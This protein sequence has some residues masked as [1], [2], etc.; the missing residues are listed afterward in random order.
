MITDGIIT[1][2]SIYSK[3]TRQ[4]LFFEIQIQNGMTYKLQGVDIKSYANQMMN[5]K[6]TRHNILQQ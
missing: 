3:I 4:P 5:T 6:A 2:F 1:G